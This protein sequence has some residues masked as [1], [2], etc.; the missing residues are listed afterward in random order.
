MYAGPDV[1]GRI[2]HLF[3]FVDTWT[4]VLNLYIIINTSIVCR[5]DIFLKWKISDTQGFQLKFFLLELIEQLQLCEVKPSY[6]T[7]FI[8]TD[9]HWKRRK[10]FYF[11][12]K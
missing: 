5:M 4:G 2:S 7:M 12:L 8:R 6:G 9:T 10:L 11:P 1:T 3:C